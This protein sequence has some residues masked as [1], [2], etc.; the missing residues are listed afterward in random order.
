MSRPVRRIVA[1]VVA[2]LTATGL[3]AATPAPAEPPVAVQAAPVSLDL[4]AEEVRELLADR[5]TRN[6]DVASRAARVAEADDR[7]SRTSPAPVAQPAPPK[8]AAPKPPK[9]TTPPR[10]QPPVQVQASG[11]LTAVIQFALAQQGKPYRWGTAGPNSYDCSGLLVASFARIGVRL[12]HQSGAIAA[13]G[14][15]VPRSQ[16][17]AGDT[18]HWPGHVALAIGGNKMI[19]ASRAGVPV[20]VVT[21]YGN[22]RVVR[23]V[24]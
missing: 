16:L 21:I 11:N 2:L 13:R 6:R 8:P 10:P 3:A 22:P 12:P 15:T 9:A 14:R 19:H 7:A 20:K 18:L 24:G 1:V 4:T 17:R 5:Q 23:I